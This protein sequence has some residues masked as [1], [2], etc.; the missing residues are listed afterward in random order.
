MIVGFAPL[1]GDGT[2]GVPECLVKNAVRSAS[3]CFDRVPFYSGQFRYLSDPVVSSEGIRHISAEAHRDAWTTWRDCESP[4]SVAARYD[5]VSA[6]GADD[7]IV[8][9]VAIHIPR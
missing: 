7:Q 3:G 2:T 1:R 4:T 9:A 6:P 8:I 5:G